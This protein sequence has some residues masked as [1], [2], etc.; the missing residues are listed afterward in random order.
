MSETD[1]F[2]QEVTEEVRQ[3]RMLAYWKRYGPFV[4]GAIVLVVAGAA[5]WNWMKAQERA[6]AESTGG[7][8]LSTNPDAPETQVD[9]ASRVDG[10]AKLIAELTSAAALASS[11]ETARAAALYADIAGRQDIALE[12]RDMAVLQGARIAATDDEATA[13]SSLEALITGSSVYRLLALELRAALSIRSGNIGAAHEDLNAIIADPQA[14]ATMRQRAG[15]I[16]AASGGSVELRG[17]G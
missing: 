10:N 11:G 3:D 15:A 16:L 4:I 5:S 6:V 9:L 12:Y 17:D 8:F 14:T 2:I 7:V 13:R 1:S